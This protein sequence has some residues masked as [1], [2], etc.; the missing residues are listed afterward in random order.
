MFVV[1]RCA[2]ISLAHRLPTLTSIWTFLNAHR[3]MSLPLKTLQQLPIVFSTSPVSLAWHIKATLLSLLSYRH[4]PIMLCLGDPWQSPRHDMLSH[5]STLGI[6]FLPCLE[7]QPPSHLSGFLLLSLQGSMWMHLLWEGKEE[8][9]VHQ[10]PRS[11][12]PGVNSQCCILAD[13][14][15]I[16][17]VMLRVMWKYHYWWWWKW[18]GGKGSQQEHYQGA[19]VFTYKS[20]RKCQCR[21]QASSFLGGS[22]EPVN[23]FG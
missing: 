10:G 21:R 1:L 7:C 16:K 3:N 14:I 13:V 23:T 17:H 6:W 4:W 18:N 8:I 11:V 2:S 15:S 9:Q 20:M 12:F 19:D 5:T 22:G